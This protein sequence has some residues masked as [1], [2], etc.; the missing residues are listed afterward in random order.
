MPSLFIGNHLIELD[1]VDSTNA[2]AA[3]LLQEKKMPEGTAVATA[4]Q[5]TGKGYSGNTWDSEKGKNLLLSIIIY[6]SFLQP[7]H[8]FFLNQI[9]SLAVA[10]TIEMFAKGKTVSIKWPNDVFAGDRKIAGILIEN[11]IQGNTIQ[12]SII[13]VGIN[14]NQEKFH[15]DLK[16]ATSLIQLIGE[17]KEL[18]SVRNELFSQ[19]ESRYLGL[20]QQRIDLLQKEYMK[21]LYRIE[22]S[23]MFVRNGTRFSGKIAG[24]TAE[25]KLVIDLGGRHEV[26]GFKEVEMVI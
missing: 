3:R 26:F 1:E 13:G 20:K 25:G 7:R 22:K 17:P 5:T 24:L 11:S 10:S 15:P 21:R 14:I 18:A 12:H 16:H 8:H 2:A 4:F 19:F 9:A 6:P 23:S